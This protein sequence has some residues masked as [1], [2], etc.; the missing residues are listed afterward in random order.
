MLSTAAPPPH[1]P[2]LAFHCWIGF[3]LNNTY[4]VHEC[5]NIKQQRSKSTDK[6]VL[7]YSEV[8]HLR[9]PICDTA[10]APQPQHN[11]T[12]TPS[13]RSAHK[14]ACAPPPPRQLNRPN[15]LVHSDPAKP[16][17]PRR[18]RSTNPFALSLSKLVLRAHEGGPHLTPTPRA[19]ASPRTH[20][21]SFP[22]T[23]T[24]V[25]PAKAGTQR[26]AARGV[27]VSRRFPTP[28]ATLTRPPSANPNPRAT[29]PPWNSTQLPLS[30]RCAPLPQGPH[31]RP[32][33]LRR[34]IPGGCLY[35]AQIFGFVANLNHAGYRSNAKTT[36]PPFSPPEQAGIQSRGATAN[37]SP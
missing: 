6:Y 15:T 21:P 23:P 4:I 11:S 2:I 22:R 24:R 14:Q 13:K 25:I 19:N 32:H 36:S 27:S 1:F 3:Q 30:R 17:P 37:R 7:D 31:R 9:Q 20:P 28:P 35:S 26:G 8:L 12:S 29:L 34:L 33:A 18:R 16:P 10:I 5:V